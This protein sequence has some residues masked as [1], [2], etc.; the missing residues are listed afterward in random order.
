[1]QWQQREK[2]RVPITL[3]NFRFKESRD[4]ALT[5]KY[6]TMWLIQRLPFK[7]IG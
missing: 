5:P 7:E 2:Q 6:Y 1:M 4:I 3:S